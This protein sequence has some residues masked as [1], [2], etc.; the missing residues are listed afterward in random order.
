MRKESKKTFIILIVLNIV[1][2]ILIG[3]VATFIY[4][5]YQKVVELRRQAIDE[6]AK[7]NDLKSLK[8]IVN[9]TSDERKY[10]QNLFVDKAKVIDFLEFI[11]SFGNLTGAKV[12]VV[13]VDEGSVD[14]PTDYVAIRFETVGSWKEV[15]NTISL[16][17]H[18]PAA[19]SVSSLDIS[20][21]QAVDNGKNPILEW[22]AVVNARVLKLNM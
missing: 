2:I 15:F 21:N 7:E 3:L 19:I 5:N 17:D 12:R 20:R 14:N 6:I 1:A 16:I 4:S 18:I 11:E 8:E 13:S 10:I 22:S 9:G